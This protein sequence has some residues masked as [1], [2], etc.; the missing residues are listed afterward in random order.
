MIA[1]FFDAID[2]PSAFDPK[3]LSRPAANLSLPRELLEVIR[4]FNK[5]D[6]NQ[7]AKHRSEFIEALRRGRRF[8]DSPLLGYDERLAILES[9]R[10]VNRQ[11]FAEYL[12]DPDLDF[13]TSDL[14]GRADDVRQPVDAEQLLAELLFTQWQARL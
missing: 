14:P 11:V 9:Y 10:Q 8:T 13:D 3:R 7:T 5:L 6:P 2:R 12:G 4:C 1:D